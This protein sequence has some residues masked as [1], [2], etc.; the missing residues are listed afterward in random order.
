ME[1]PV[2]EA[3]KV[4]GQKGYSL[5]GQ[6]ALVVYHQHWKLKLKDVILIILDFVAYHRTVFLL[7]LYDTILVF[8]HVVFKVLL[9]IYIYLEVE[10]VA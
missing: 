6:Q 8:R 3:K 10:M 7:R 5:V 2:E 1:G 4:A 9:I